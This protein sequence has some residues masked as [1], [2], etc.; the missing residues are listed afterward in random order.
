M[1]QTDVAGRS[2]AA[3]SKYKTTQ[4]RITAG[5]VVTLGLCAYAYFFRYQPHPFS[6]EDFE[7]QRTIVQYIAF[8]TVLGI[9]RILYDIHLDMPFMHFTEDRFYLDHDGAEVGGYWREVTDISEIT[10]VKRGVPTRQKAV[11][12]TYGNE[13]Q[14]LI[15]PT[16]INFRDSDVRAIAKEFWE[17]A[18]AKLD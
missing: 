14:F 3:F 12:L 17:K 8:G 13:N 18:L 4:F 1:I 7:L 6:G 15:D 10:V 16:V 11:V 9:G 2:F 5:L